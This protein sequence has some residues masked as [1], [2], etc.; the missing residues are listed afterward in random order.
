MSYS[1][2]YGVKKLKTYE[3][4]KINSIKFEVFIN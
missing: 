1:N 4:E 3:I 2:V